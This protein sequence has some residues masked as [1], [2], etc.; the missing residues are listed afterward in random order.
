MLSQMVRHRFSEVGHPL[1]TPMGDS[2]VTS[3]IF[4]GRNLAA[5]FSRR[6]LLLALSQ[7]LTPELVPGVNPRTG[8]QG[9]ASSW[10][11]RTGGHTG[12]G[13]IS[14]TSPR[15]LARMPQRSRRE[16]GVKPAAPITPDVRQIRY[17]AGIA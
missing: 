1:G 3:R 11:W 8:D 5:L 17:A 6:F 9:F 12:S 10:C 7:G 13:T 14:L 15:R 4:A 16:I 2:R